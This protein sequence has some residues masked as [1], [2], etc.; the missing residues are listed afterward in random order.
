MQSQEEAEEAQAQN[1][2]AENKLQEFHHEP[3]A[4]P[5]TQ[6][7]FAEQSEVSEYNELPTK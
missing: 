2:V 4:D 1:K 6:N 7:K 5:R 3:A